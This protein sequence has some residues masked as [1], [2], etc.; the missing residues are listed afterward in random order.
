MQKLSMAAL[1]ALVIG[2]VGCSGDYTGGGV[3][4]SASGVKGEK[5]TFGFRLHAENDGKSCD[6]II[7]GSGEFNYVDH[8][9]GIDVAF[10]ARVRTIQGAFWSDEDEVGGPLF[11]ADYY[12]NGKLA[13]R[14]DIG[15]YDFGKGDK[16]DLM[17]VS[18]TSGP[19]AG[20]FN[21]GRFDKGN[22]TY[23]PDPLCK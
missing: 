21:A 15:V 18:V 20:Y 14:V 16:T 23:H 10:H 22:I 4:P 17:F 19:F 1:V 13:G 11:T 9:K 5:A 3:L 7:G 2:L 6:E 12:V 8:G